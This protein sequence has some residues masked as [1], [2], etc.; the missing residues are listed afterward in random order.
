M[1]TQ[2][3][4]KENQEFDKVVSILTPQFKRTCDFSYAK[5]RKRLVNK[6]WAISGIAAMFLVVLSVAIKSV[7]PASATE[8]INS[9]FTTLMN[10]ESIKVEFEW[11]GVK[12]SAEEIYSP[13]PSGNVINGTLYLLRK[14]GKVNMRI[15]WQDTEKNSIVFNGCDYI[16]LQD[17]HIANKYPT[18]FDGKL[19]ELFSQKTLPD[20]LKG[21]SELSTE[22]NRIMIKHHK[23]NITFYGEFQKDSKRLVKASAIISLP[24]EK[25]ITLLETKSIETGIDISESMFLE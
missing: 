10:A 16:H 7:L 15:D 21:T 4:I 6:I 24:E 5:P 9:A 25:N 20:Y 14:D 11:R 3:S 2:D 23:E 1:S 8:L 22:G 19:M 17:N 12:T 18:A 13:D